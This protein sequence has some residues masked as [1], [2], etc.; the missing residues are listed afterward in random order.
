MLILCM[1][2]KFGSDTFEDCGCRKIGTE[3]LGALRRREWRARSVILG[4]EMPKTI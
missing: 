1:L 3:L 4:A 2:C